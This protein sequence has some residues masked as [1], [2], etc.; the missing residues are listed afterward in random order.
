MVRVV[1]RFGDL[2]KVQIMAERIPAKRM[3]MKYLVISFAISTIFVSSCVAAAKLSVPKTRQVKTL[4]GEFE[5]ATDEGGR[6]AAFDKMLALGEPVFELVRPMIDDALGAEGR[7]YIKILEPKIRGAYIKKLESLSDEQ[8]SHILRT[9][10][11]WEPYILNG[12]SDPKF[13]QVY[14]APIWKMKEF[15]L[16]K[17]AD[18]EDTEVVTLRK[19]LVEFAGYQRQCHEALKISPDP[20][21]GKLSPTGIE[22]AHLDRPPTFI[23]KLHHYE[24]TLILINT[25]ASK[26]AREV[27]LMTDQAAREI[28]VQE[29]EYVM[30]ANEVRMLAG[31]IAWRADP[32]GCAVERDHSTDRKEGR[33]KGH[34]SS[35]PGKH[36]FGDRNR[37]MGAGHYGSEGA[38]GGRNGPAYLNGLSYSGDGHGGPLYRLARNRVGVGRRGGVYTSQY[39]T[40]KKYIHPCPATKH[41]M[42]MPPGI[43]ASD[44]RTSAIKQAYLAMKAKSC[45]SA[46]GSLDRAKSPTGAD[47]I[48]LRFFRTAID[49]EVQQAIKDILATEGSG[50]VFFARFL[51]RRD[52]ARLKGIE[53]FEKAVADSSQ[54]LNARDLRPEMTAGEAYYRLYYAVK[55]APKAKLNANRSA[56]I[57]RLGGITSK[58]KDS[59]YA[60]AA[61]DAAGRLANPESDAGALMAFFKERRKAD[62]P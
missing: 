5:A 6:K 60:K 51:L 40:D 29:A 16:L 55:D 23:D 54:R 2:A 11:L 17:I 30:A 1:K 13:R 35:V 56:L 22:Y 38:G 39:A 52:L 36:G 19:K 44:L 32:L 25:V 43:T 33:A 57:Q 10:Y 18:I 3:I 41:E 61:E 4:F 49:V 24:R 21:V 27:L 53:A 12:G 9:R 50:D 14:L 42:W 31:S 7:K 62:R 37:R 15:L 46:L 20:T 34:M 47:A 59:I 8:I 48:A 28:D 45:G 58:Y 26:G